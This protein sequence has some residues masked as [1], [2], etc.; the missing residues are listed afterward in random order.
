MPLSGSSI[1]EHML[2]QMR[3][4]MLEAQGKG[5]IAADSMAP[6]VGFA[7]ELGRYL[8]R[9]SAAQNEA[10]AKAKAFELGAPDISLSD[11]MIDLQKVSIG[12]QTTLQVRKKLVEAYKEISTMAV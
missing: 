5:T 6:A 2:Q 8:K 3:A 10:T 4:V 7:A 12:F 11:V 9:L 1:I